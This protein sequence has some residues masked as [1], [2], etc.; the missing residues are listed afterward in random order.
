[1][2]MA[3]TSKL[4]EVL[5]LA[6][7]LAV[8]T[9]H[10]FAPITALGKTTTRSYGNPLRLYYSQEDDLASASPLPMT[11]DD[12]ARL[13]SMRS[14]QVTVPVMI[15]D[16]MLPKQV[17]TF[18]SSDPTFLQMLDYSYQQNKSKQSIGVFGQHPTTGKC[19]CHGVLATIETVEYPV[20][21]NS[22]NDAKTAVTV[23]VTAE[24]CLELQGEPWQI[25]GGAFS[26]AECELM[27]AR[28]ENIE[29]LAKAAKLAATLPAMIQQW[30]EV[31]VASGLTDEEGLATREQV[32]GG[33]PVV[34][35]SS[36]DVDVDTL[37]EYW[38]DISF[39]VASMLNPIPQ[40]PGSFDV[41]PAMLS[42]P[43]PM[44]RLLLA[45]TALQ[46]NMDDLRGKRR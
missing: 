9:A 12:M 7:T 45:A 16:A 36:L 17:L 11:N 18:Q 33:M 39:F 6:M 35:E 42:A 44:E 2:T 10:S 43:T 28:E 29:D 27:D 25:L 22:V 38:T 15:L 34:D 1:M 41:R 13:Q 26:V 32:L 24:K 4:L 5:F 31:L 40:I 14:R 20:V 21:H 46:S 23:R 19:L 30:K 3:T 37:L 8:P